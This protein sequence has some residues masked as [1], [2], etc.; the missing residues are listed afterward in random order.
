MDSINDFID[1][2]KNTL[3]SMSVIDFIDI[4]IVSVIIYYA[5]KFIIDKRAA[6][7]FIGIFFLSVSYLISDMLQMNALSFIL[8]N[9]FQVGI[10]ALIIVFHPELRSMLEKVGG[11]PLNPINRI[12][13]QRTVQKTK[14]T[15]DTIV[16]AASDFSV[17]K[18][19]ALIVIERTT[20]LGDI[21]KNSI[22]INAELSVFML[23]TIFFD[24][25]PLHD[26]AVIISNNLIQTAGCFL[27]LSQN[28]TDLEG[29]GTRHRA[30]LGISEESDAVVIIVSEENGVISTAV[31]GKL[32]RN[33]NAYSLKSELSRLL[34]DNVV[35]RKHGSRKG[36]DSGE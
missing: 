9:L 36:K 22:V 6:K 10:I 19:G 7:L 30:G 32:T 5:I 23:K 14:A 28:T 21:I 24:K 27:P 26:G 17:A 20:K 29:L 35:I 11:T 18:T 1:Y 13:A 4:A 33:F 15:I 8:N 25:A 3:L 31:D 12:V 34:S 16:N 2:I